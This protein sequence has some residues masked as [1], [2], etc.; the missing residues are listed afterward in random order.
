MFALENFF[1]FHKSDFFKKSAFFLKNIPCL[2][3]CIPW[4][5]LGALGNLVRAPRT[6]RRS[7]WP[8]CV[9]MGSA[10]I[11]L[12]GLGSIRISR[13]SSYDCGCGEVVWGQALS[14]SAAQMPSRRP[15]VIRIA[16]QPVLQG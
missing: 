3:L 1:F 7:M 5:K 11:V 10:D 15:T 12:P 6:I 4:L 13:T 2:K 16:I 9:P 8:Q 14:R